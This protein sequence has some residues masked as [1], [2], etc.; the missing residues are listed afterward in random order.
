MLKILPIMLFSS[1]E[2]LLN[3]KLINI[4]DTTVQVQFKIYWLNLL[5]YSF[6]TYILKSDVLILKIK[7]TKLSLR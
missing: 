7:K 3:I 4:N 6:P 1:A 2:K 5:N